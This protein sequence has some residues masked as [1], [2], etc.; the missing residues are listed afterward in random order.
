MPSTVLTTRV[1]PHVHALL[2]ELAQ[3]RGTSLAATAAHLL[4]A[5]V[6]DAGDT[7]PPTD[8]ALVAAVRTLLADVTDPAAVL[9]RETAVVLARAIE[10][11]EPGHLGA[12]RDLRRAVEG[13]QQAQQH[14][15]GDD[16]DP[17]ALLGLLGR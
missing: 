12:V 7:P 6:D 5:A 3:R 16:F 17:A 10:R 14:A 11:R 13:A 2:V 9:H 15:D 4:T 8:G 1:P